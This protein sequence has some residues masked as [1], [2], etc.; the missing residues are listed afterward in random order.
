MEV[1]NDPYIEIVFDALMI[2]DDA[3]MV[4]DR[5]GQYTVFY[6]ILVLMQGPVWVFTLPSKPVFEGLVC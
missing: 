5:A 6:Y 3:L 4:Y 2:Y 1:I